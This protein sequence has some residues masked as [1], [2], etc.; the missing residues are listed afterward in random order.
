[1]LRYTVSRTEAIEMLALARE[2]QSIYD[3]VHHPDFLRSVAVIAHDLPRP[4]RLAVNAAGLD[5]QKPALLISGNPVDDGR[6]EST[7]GHWREAD[8]P[9][10]RA[11]AFLLLICAEL[12]GTAVGWASQQD[13]R[14]VTDVVPTPGLE[15]SLVSGSS[16]K[17]LGWHTED[18]FSPYRADHVGLYCLRSPDEIATTLAT[19]DLTTL[20]SEIADI[21]SQQRFHILPDTSHGASTQIDALR[22]A[23]PT[24]ALLS[25]ARDAPVLRI[26]RDFT[27]A[28]SGDDEAAKALDWLVDHLDR[29]L[30]DVTLRPGDI[31]FVDNRNTV[32][33]RRPFRPRYDG[34]DRWLKRVNVVSELRHSRPARSTTT[35]RV[36]G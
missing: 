32:H 27:Q 31:C 25:G 11:Y 35:S 16:R 14:L 12:L 6:L 9:G 22:S 15:E 17:E 36:I 4:L 3:D 10:S 19:V 33:G 24:V 18:A 21:L 29:R 5:D 2:C 30:Y 28:M 7:P 20:P 26:D 8:T 13:G 23:P 34:T 1:M